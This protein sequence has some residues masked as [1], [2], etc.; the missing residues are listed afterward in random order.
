M[1]AWTLKDIIQLSVYQASDSDK[2]LN[3]DVDDDYLSRLDKE[4]WSTADKVVAFI[5]I[6]FSLS[7]LVF[8]AWMTG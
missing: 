5:P 2:K 8:L 4:P 3:I 7:L 1:M 6:L